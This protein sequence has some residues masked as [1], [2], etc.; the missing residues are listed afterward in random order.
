MD[1]LTLIETKCPKGHLALYRS[2]IGQLSAKHD[3]TII[4]YDTYFHDLG[5]NCK[6]KSL[7]ED[8]E[9]YKGFISYRVQQAL[10]TKRGLD[11]ADGDVLFL[12][13][14]TVSLF[15]NY[16][17]LVKH[18]SK[19]LVIEHNNIDQLKRS[20]VKQFCYQLL[21]K[22]I[23]HLTFEN[24]IAN[25]LA[26][27]YN[28]TTKVI[29]HPSRK[30]LERKETLKQQFLFAPSADS[31]YLFLEQV[32]IC[33]NR[34]N[35]HLYAKENARFD[36]NIYVHTKQ[37]FDN[38]E[39]LMLNARAIVIAINYDYRVSAVFYEALINQKKILFKDCLYAREMKKK[40]PEQ[41][42]ILSGSGDFTSMLDQL[43]N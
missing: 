40:F 28:K 11:L 12:S 15:L 43:F 31:D 41:V 5:I 29:K 8:V 36:G 20:K 26:E 9:K 24:Y 22:T 13:Y 39:S 37:Y 7:G 23:V 3:L 17:T 27:R 25:F 2:L 35:V 16:R 33:C 34:N 38:Y 1:K 6:Y 18:R 4:S 32:A 10:A 21:P 19:I 30:F 14:D 42:S